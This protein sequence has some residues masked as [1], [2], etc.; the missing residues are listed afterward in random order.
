M[1][2]VEI[3]QIQ[4]CT[5]GYCTH[6]HTGGGINY[7]QIW[8]DECLRL[9][10][11]KMLILRD[12]HHTVTCSTVSGPWKKK[13]V[14][15]RSLFLWKVCGRFWCQKWSEVVWMDGRQSG[16][17]KDR[18]GN[19]QWNNCSTW[20]WERTSTINADINIQAFHTQSPTVWLHT[21]T[22]ILTYT[23]P[24]SL[25]QTH[26]QTYM[27]DHTN[28]HTTHTHTKRIKSHK[29]NSNMPL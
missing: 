16:V 22:Y 2:Q 3:L 10:W 13:H 23:P 26:T 15:Q 4:K 27:C 25:W 7:M 19:F 9:A 29:E 6:T 8:R 21:D 28:T 24:P 20:P 11:K 14:V 12:E 5:A 18:L 17:Q 1:I